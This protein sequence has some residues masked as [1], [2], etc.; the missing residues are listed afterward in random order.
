M[1]EFSYIP[2]EL[3]SPLAAPGN[4]RRAEVILGPRQVGKSTLLGHLAQ[5]VRHITLTGE[6]DDDLAI[7]ADPKS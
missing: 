3:E 1:L 5:N 4:A 2:R 7:L 6:D